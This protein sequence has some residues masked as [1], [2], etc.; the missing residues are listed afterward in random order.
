[1][2]TKWLKYRSSLRNKDNNVDSAKEE[3]INNNT[4]TV[5]YYKNI[6]INTEMQGVKGIQ[7]ITAKECTAVYIIICKL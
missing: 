1:M 3:Y 7:N 2:L 6:P 5:I 4:K